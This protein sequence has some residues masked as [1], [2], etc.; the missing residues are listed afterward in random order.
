M[1]AHKTH[2]AIAY[3]LNKY[4][5]FIEDEFLIGNVL[6]DLSKDKN[7]K[8]AHCRYNYNSVTNYAA[9]DIFYSLYR[10]K[11]DNPLIIGYLT[12][13][14][15]DAFYNRYV[16]NNKYI[17]K[18]NRIVSII[19]KDG[20]IKANKEVAKTIKHN[21]FN[22]FDCFLLNQ[23]TIPYI[24]EKNY[25]EVSN[26]DIALFE[27][28]SIREYIRNHNKSIRM[29]HLHQI[30]ENSFMMF[31]IEELKTLLVKCCEAVDLY[32]REKGII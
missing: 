21:D 3:E 18:D 17:I 14:Y 29:H 23:L 15:V 31:S 2:I 19:L 6:P 1:P 26:L 20:S 25:S 8:M 13:L 10:R 30:E 16:T 27:A 5:G 7:H 32:L 4:Y 11:M 22:N 12:H 24:N 28:S 9:P